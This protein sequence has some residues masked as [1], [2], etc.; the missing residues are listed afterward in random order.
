MMTLSICTDLNLHERKYLFAGK[1]QSPFNFQKKY[2]KH[3][4][5]QFQTLLCEEFMIEVF[6]NDFQNSNF[7]TST[8]RQHLSVDNALSINNRK[9]FSKFLSNHVLPR[10][11]SCVLLNQKETSIKHHNWLVEVFWRLWLNWL[12]LSRNI[13][14]TKQWN[15]F[16][17]WC[18]RWWRTICVQSCHVWEEQRSAVLFMIV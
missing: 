5:L 11:S 15:I 7:S 17:S 10:W 3:H 13:F 9:W 18:L 16:Q 14:P 8:T 4:H 12:L 1:R 2:S 6:L